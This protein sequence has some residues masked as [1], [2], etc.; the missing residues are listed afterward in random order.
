MKRRLLYALLIL[1]FI[2]AVPGS[3]MAQTY[4]FSLDELIVDVY[5]NEDG[6]VDVEYV[7]VATNSPNTDPLEFFDVGMPNANFSLSNVS[8]NV[9]G[10]PI[11]DIESSPF[12]ENGIALGLGNNAI[13][14]GTTG[15]VYI[16]VRGISRV[17]F[18]DDQ[19][20]TYASAVFSTT[21]FDRQFLFGTTRT[22]VTYHLPPSVLPDEPRWHSAP[23]GF[24]AEPATGIDDQG[25]VTYTWVNSQANGYTPYKFG[26]SFPKTAVP[27]TAVVT[28]TISDRLQVPWEDLIMGFI[29]FGFAAFFFGIIVFSIVAAQKRQ[30][31][32]LPPKIA[33]EGHGVKRGLTAIEAA[34]L[35]EQP[36][37]K[38]MTMILFAVIK[39]GV[40]EVTSK[41]PLELKHTGTLPDD[42]REYELDFV[43]AFET[44]G[45][46]RRKAMQDTM[47]ELVKSVSAKMKGFS[48]KETIEYYQD[49]MRKAW[50]QVEAAGT[51]EVM[52]EKFDEVMEWTMLDR[53][54]DGHTREVF[55]ERPVFVPTWWGRYDPTFGR[56]AGLP[57]G[58]QGSSVPYPSGG[59]TSMPTI[60]GSAFAASVVT[61]IQN[62]SSNVVGN[63]TDFTSAVTNKTNPVPKTTSSGGSS[64][65]GG[66]GCACACACAGCACACAGGGR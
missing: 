17:L 32:Y 65:S 35:M 45:T 4:Y 10:I 53:D 8:A 55:R 25:R 20:S 11:T 2:S 7:F 38:I 49:I 31:Q 30:L 21:Y 51:P 50:A 34:I 26:A 46:A 54:F 57:S 15:S 29:C 66:G 6:T 40:V 43:S 27:E 36:M 28:A 61:S 39:K 37:D 44:K 19:D 24:P 62:F 48:R 1:L 22:S 52:S 5:W 23:S 14:P 47:V 41:D 60:P 12:V 64:R 13:K 33:I 63:V 9:D 42:L 3:V 59:G 58:G 18:E 56:T 16:M